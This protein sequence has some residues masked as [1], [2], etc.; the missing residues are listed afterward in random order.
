M[1]GQRIKPL[2]GFVLTATTDYDDCKRPLC[3]AWGVRNQSL[4]SFSWL[5][6][7]SKRGFL[8]STDITQ[9]PIISLNIKILVAV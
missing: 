5:I 7:S 1:H 6:H 2:M 4:R 8:M 3:G 9:Y